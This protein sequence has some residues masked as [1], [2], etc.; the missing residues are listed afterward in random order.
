MLLKRLE[1]KCWE[2]MLDPESPLFEAALLALV[3]QKKKR[4]QKKQKKAL[5]PCQCQSA[6]NDVNAKTYQFN[7]T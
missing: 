5:L 1:T 3:Q 2:G 4:N 6:V 7:S